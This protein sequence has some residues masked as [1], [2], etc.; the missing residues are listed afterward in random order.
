MSKVD[1]IKILVL[2]E[3]FLGINRNYSFLKKSV[4]YLVKMRILVELSFICISYVSVLDTFIGNSNGIVLSIRVIF[5][6][7]YISFQT[8]NSLVAIVLSFANAKHFENFVKNIKMIESLLDCDIL[9]QIRRQ[10]RITK[11][12]VNMTLFIVGMI[13]MTCLYVHDSFVSE[14]LSAKEF[15]LKISHHYRYFYENFV[16]VQFIQVLIFNLKFLNDTVSVATENFCKEIDK[17]DGHDVLLS[18]NQKIKTWNE[19][20][21]LLGS[22][23][24]HLYHCFGI[25]VTTCFKQASLL[26][27]F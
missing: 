9:Y 1:I 10:N 5:I 22:A 17:T 18:M 16:F 2:I 8:A 20:N 19:V 24:N 13:F 11:F 21:Y 3:N 12:Y 14:K 26:S 23:S 27:S 15:F 7:Y 4:K 25:Q 6:I